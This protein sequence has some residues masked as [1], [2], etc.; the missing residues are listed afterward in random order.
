[1][2]RRRDAVFLGRFLRAV[3]VFLGRFRWAGRRSE[4]G[5]FRQF[6]AGGTE[7]SR[8]TN[9]H[10]GGVVAAG[11]EPSTAT[12]GRRAQGTEATTQGGSWEEDGE[13]P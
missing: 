4:R 7:G 12:A 3:G 11:P 2:V 5:S 9:L 8:Q 13:P 6:G 10:V 1:M